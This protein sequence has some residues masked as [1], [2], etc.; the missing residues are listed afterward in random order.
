[1]DD[2]SF[3]YVLATLAQGIPTTLT[4]TFLGFGIGLVGGFPVALLR[5]SRFRVIRFIAGSF[6]EIVRGIPP[7]VWLFIIFFGLPRTGVA[8]F[9]EMT[10]AVLAFGLI[11]SAYLAEIYRSSISSVP[12][13]QWDSS[14]ALGLPSVATYRYVIGPQA[15]NLAVPPAA[16]FLVGLL[17]DSAIA[18][19]IGVGD[20][21]FRAFIETQRTFE[22][23]YILSV[24]A[25]LYVAIS[26][27]M[28]IAS[29]ILDNKLRAHLV[30][31]EA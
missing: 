27:P 5:R 17:K 16:T 8:A 1:M 22:G 14:V 13:G 9:N 12:H 2:L 30:R 3:G 24:A 26:I 19:V 29:R 25:L 7:L 20:I 4:I 23:F 10:S 6:V 15:L 21:T 31:N 28:A 18:S 11:A